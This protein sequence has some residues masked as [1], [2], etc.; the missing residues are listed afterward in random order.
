MVRWLSTLTIYA[1][2][3]AFLASPAAAKPVTGHTDDVV[4]GN[5]TIVSVGEGSVGESESSIGQVPAPLC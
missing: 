5:V 4:F 1:G 3:L 2:C